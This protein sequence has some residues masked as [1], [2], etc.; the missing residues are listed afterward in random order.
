VV[1]YA[2]AG[3]LNVPIHGTVDAPFDLVN[4]GGNYMSDGMGRGFSS[5]LVLTE[6]TASSNFGF[7]DHDEVAV[8]HLMLQYMGVDEYVKMAVLPYDG[9]HHIDMHMKLL[10]ESTLLV[11]QYPEGI[12]DGPQIEA[13][14]MYMVEEFK[15]RSGHDYK[16]VRIP[17]PPDQ[18]DRYPNSN[19]HY[20]TYANAIFINKTILV[21]TYE[22][23]YDTTALRIWWETMP[24]YRIIGIDCNEIIPAS[25]ALHCITKEVGVHWPFWI[26]HIQPGKAQY[27]E[28]ILLE[29]GA[30][31]I[32][33]VQDLWAFFRVSGAAEYDSI[34]M[35]TPPGDV[36]E[37]E[38]PDFGPNVTIEYYFKGVA[39]DGTTQVRPLPAPEG[40][41]RLYIEE[42]TTYSQV[43]A[44]TGFNFEIFPN[45]S[46]A[47]TCVS[48][49]NH[50]STDGKVEVY[51][52]YG[53]K[54]L[55]IFEG[56]IPAGGANYFVD[57]SRLGTGVYLVKVSTKHFEKT[58]MLSVN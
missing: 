9:I 52:I 30:R 26:T 1:P 45:P 49:D 55:T 25:G 56:E 53:R 29:A 4:T 23:R 38:L 39:G 28:Q 19:G 37:F 13:N 43:L 18:F 51:D 7:S 3:H 44:K 24:G 15:Q 20:R 36:W 11:G 33:G 54:V 57:A 12:A 47:I 16:V 32:S 58:L 50:I 8:D 22:E 27:G 17:M 14:L 10:D 31:H 35:A 6:N 21:P 46:S 5:N 34:Q 41:F 48:V 40:Y 42:E 2:V